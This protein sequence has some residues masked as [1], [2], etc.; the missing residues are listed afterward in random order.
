MIRSLAQAAAGVAAVALLLGSGNPARAGNILYY[1]DFL[2]GTDR[3]LDALTDLQS[4]GV[5]TFT[6]V[7]SSSAFITQL[8]TGNYDLAVFMIQGNPAPAD[9][10]NALAAY[11]AAGGRAIVADWYAPD[12]IFLGQ[13]GATHAG[14][15]DRL[16]YSVLPPLD[17]GLTNPVGVINPGWNI[18]TYDLALTPG[19]T[20]AGNFTGGGPAIAIGPDG[21]TIVNGFLDDTFADG[22]QGRQLYENEINVL[23]SSSVPEPGTLTL[24]ALGVLSLAGYGWRRRRAA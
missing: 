15:T 20:V 2:A 4:R 1:V 14:P 19:S 13:F 23:T 12:D 17:S 8:A 10:F 11:H 7:T 3:M 9:A 21:R 6:Q 24:F 16:Q 18:F 22:I 5:D